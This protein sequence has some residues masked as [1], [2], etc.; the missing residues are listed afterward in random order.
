MGSTIFVQEEIKSCF[1]CWSKVLGYIEVLAPMSSPLHTQ[2]NT[3][4]NIANTRYWAFLLLLFKLIWDLRSLHW[5]TFLSNSLLLSAFFPWENNKKKS[6][7][8]EINLSFSSF[9]PTLVTL[10]VQVFVV[11]TN[12]PNPFC[13]DFSYKN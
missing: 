3:K 5:Q 8:Q 1:N 7:F 2:G 13:D 10:K 12:I 9:S 6:I 11:I 4:C